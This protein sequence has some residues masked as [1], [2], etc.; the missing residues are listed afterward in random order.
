MDTKGIRLFVLAADM[1]N[2]SSAGRKL[3]LAP[4]VASARLSKLEH[5]LGADLFIDLRGRLLY[6]LRVRNSFPSPGRFLRKRTQLW[7]RL[8]K[9]VQM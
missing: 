7:Q 8:V 4:S 3:G 2:I 5:Q 1:L 6:P 9:A